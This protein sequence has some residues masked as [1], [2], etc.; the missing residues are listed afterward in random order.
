MAMS[1]GQIKGP[2]Q[3]GEDVVSL[4]KKEIGTKI[5]FYKIFKIGINCHIGDCVEI[6]GQSI[7][8]G[9][10]G[11]FELRDT[12]ID[13]LIFQQKEDVDTSIEYI[14]QY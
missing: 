9:K 13:S 5:N 8:I 12:N 14:I 7:E 2:F 3:Q 6:N 1:I 11:M 10:T 4:I